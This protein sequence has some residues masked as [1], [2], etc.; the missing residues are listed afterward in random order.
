MIDEPVL[1]LVATI[2]GTATFV[3]DGLADALRAKG[4]RPFVVAME[5]AA[6]KMFETRRLFII[7]SSTHGT[8]DIPDN[9]L[10]FFETLRDSRPDLTRVR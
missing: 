9:D 3:A 4:I 10:P 8:G 2:G 6:L 5:K 7:C 1:I